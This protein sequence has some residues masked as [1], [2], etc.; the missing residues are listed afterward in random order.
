M[1]L[2]LANQFGVIEL[3]HFSNTSVTYGFSQ[4]RGDAKGSLR[5]YYILL[6]KIVIA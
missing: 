1:I 2:K 6:H 5:E 4:R 3:L